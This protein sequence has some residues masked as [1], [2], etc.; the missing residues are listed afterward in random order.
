MSDYSVVSIMH[1]EMPG[2]GL[3]SQPISTSTV[4]V[5][6]KVELV[7][8]VPVIVRIST[9]QGS[10]TIQGQWPKRRALTAHPEQATSRLEKA[11]H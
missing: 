9:A 6:Q 2:K 3:R 10:Y 1:D 7:R 11:F 4:S 5:L 8:M